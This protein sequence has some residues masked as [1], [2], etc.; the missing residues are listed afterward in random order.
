MRIPKYRAF[1]KNEKHIYEVVLL[2]WSAEYPMQLAKMVIIPSIEDGTYRTV[3]GY[4]TITNNYE[5][6]QYT[7]LH[8]KYG[9]EVY[10]G[11][12]VRAN[13]PWED[14][15]DI[16]QVV[17]YVNGSWNYSYALDEYAVKPATGWEIVGN[18][19]EHPELIKEVQQ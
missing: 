9:K 7:G 16:L 5:L 11:D 17:R 18:I 8:D 10:E 15:S 4:D 2:E 13:Y 12:I 14:W 6:M 19:W 1:G 3:H